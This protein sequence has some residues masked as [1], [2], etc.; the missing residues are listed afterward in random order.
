MVTEQMI[1]AV[2]YAACIAMVCGYLPQS[3]YTIR[4]R[5]TDA[6]ALPTFLLMGV[7]SVLF[8][9][10]GILTKNMPLVITNAITSVCCV[11]V[12]SIKIYNDFIRPKK[13]PKKK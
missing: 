11:I 6:I 8:V 1:N 7:G 3:I 10:Q 9:V 12:T 2:G 5:E 13:D 4:T